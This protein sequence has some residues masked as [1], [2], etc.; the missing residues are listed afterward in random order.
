[1]AIGDMLY[2]LATR[3]GQTV[4]LKV[5]SG[6]SYDPST[7]TMSGQSETSLSVIAVVSGAKSKVVDGVA[8]QPGDAVAMVPV[9]AALTAAPVAGMSRVTVDSVDRTVVAVEPRRDR[10]VVGGYV[11]LLRGA[12]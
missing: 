6:G 12:V 2:G 5:K 8:V 11:C 3:R 4:T 1:M 7:G 10:G 9:Q